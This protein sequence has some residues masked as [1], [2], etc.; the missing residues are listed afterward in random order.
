MKLAIWAAGGVAVTALSVGLT[1][2]IVNR[3]RMQ[4]GRTHW[5]WLH[6]AIAMGMMPA[7]CILFFVCFDNEFRLVPDPTTHFLLIMGMFAVG[8]G[9]L[10]ILVMF[11]RLFWPAR[12]IP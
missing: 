7:G 8:A 6:F 12:R 10:W 9:P 3:R 11:V 1:V 2:L 4:A 5:S